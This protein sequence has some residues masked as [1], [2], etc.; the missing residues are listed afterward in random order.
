M[1]NIDLADRENANARGI[2]MK[3]LSGLVCLLLLLC[4]AGLAQANLIT[5]GDFETLPSNLGSGS[6]AI[7][8]S[9]PGWTLYT[10]EA[11]IQHGMFGAGN[12]TN[13]TELDANRNVR[14]GQSVSL[15][16][17][18]TYQ[19]SFDYFNRQQSLTS[20]SMSVSIGDFTYETA[21]LGP[22]W[23]TLTTSFVYTGA[24][25]SAILYLSGTGTS[26]SYGALVD[27]ISLVQTKAAPTPIPGAVWLLGT[28]LLALLAFKRRLPA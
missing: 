21:A 10:G 7:Y 14:M 1:A 23:A 16:K 8:S 20:G 15:T 19:L 18:A 17:G 4:T 2:H 13:Y 24:S 3:K 25:P 9:L 5:N 22:K 27:N 26:D 28:A 11:E 6:W 12:P